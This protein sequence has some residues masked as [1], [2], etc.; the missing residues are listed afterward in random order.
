MG[1]HYFMDGGE[2]LST[3]ELDIPFLLFLLSF[4]VGLNT[5]AR[6]V[7]FFFFTKI[8][9]LPSNSEAFLLGF[10]VALLVNWFFG[11]LESF[12]GS[13][14][15]QRVNKCS[16]YMPSIN[17]SFFLSLLGDTVITLCKFFRTSIRWWAF[18]GFRNYIKT[19]HVTR[20]LLSILADLNNAVV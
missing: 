13:L 18:T 3:F 19:P 8:W 15:K 20:T 7:R 11:I 6:L 2:V 16:D 10:I 5:R 9:I 17:L 14:P 12:N 4:R 1:L